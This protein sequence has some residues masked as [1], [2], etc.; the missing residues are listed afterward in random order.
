MA[1]EAHHQPSTTK[2]YLMK[3]QTR[4]L[5][6]VL[7]LVTIALIC[8][9]VSGQFV[10]SDTTRRER[11]AHTGRIS[12]EGLGDRSAA[13][14]ALSGFDNLSNGFDLQGPDY[15]T[16]EEDNVVPLRSFND[17]RFVFEEVESLADGLGPTYN[18]Q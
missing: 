18:A 5:A 6:A 16:L 13:T 11:F 2:H 12:Y 9:S 4:N 10:S 3:S 15:G 1:T 17:N 8:L 14:E 7:G